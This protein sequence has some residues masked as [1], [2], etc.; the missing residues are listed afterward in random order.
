MKCLVGLGSNL[1][2]SVAT[3]V[4]ARKDV[5]ELPSTFVLGSSSLYRTAPVGGPEQADFI[6][7]VLLVDSPAEPTDFLQQ[8][9]AIENKHARVRTERWGPRT[10]DLDIIDV[11]GFR[12]NSDALHI[13]HPRARERAFVLVPAREV[14]PTWMLGDV[15]LANL[16]IPADQPIES[17][18]R[19]E[20]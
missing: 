12:S 4:A 17:F 1:G 18:Y 14:A 13:P 11:A 8:L 6:N 5:S 10:L 2:D 15:E 9:Q 16:S 20:W 19:A 7:A 3:L